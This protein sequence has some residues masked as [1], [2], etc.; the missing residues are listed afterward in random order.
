M[1]GAGDG[2]FETNMTWEELG[3]LRDAASK[4]LPFILFSLP[5]FFLSPLFFVLSFSPFLPPFIAVC[6]LTPGIGQL[7]QLNTDSRH[8]LLAHL[9]RV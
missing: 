3:T 6:H 1:V 7:K 8:A 4:I 9:G 5:P 2:S